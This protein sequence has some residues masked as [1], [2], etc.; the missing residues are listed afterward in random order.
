MR[1]GGSAGPAGFRREGLSPGGPDGRTGG[2]GQPGGGAG[3]PRSRGAWSP[4]RPGRA[5]AARSRRG[6][7]ARRTVLPG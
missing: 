2:P 4:P 1:P 7:P 6:P 3:P 5:R